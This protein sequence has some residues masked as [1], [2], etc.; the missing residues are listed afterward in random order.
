M[1]LNSKEKAFDLVIFDWD[2][3]LMDTVG[4]IVSCMQNVAQELMLP[5]PS[6]QQVRDVIG[7]SLP[8]IMPILFADHQNHQ[9]IIDCYRRHHLASELLTPLFDGVELLI[10]NLFDAGYHLAIATGKGR[11]GLDNVLAL[12]GLGDYFHATRCADDA[13]SKPHPEML[14]SL[15]AHFDVTADRAIMIGDSIHDLAMANN[16]GMASIGVSYGAHN[17]SRLNLLNPRAIVDQP[18]AIRDYL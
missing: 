9:Q 3:T 16:A 15:L 10:R 6:E 18:C 14:Y 4:K 13:Q 12:T 5:I 2:G 17:E 8:Q 7:L 11:Q 1:I